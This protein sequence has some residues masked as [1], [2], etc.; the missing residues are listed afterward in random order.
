MRFIAKIALASCVLLAVTGSARADF[1]PEDAQKIRSGLMQAIRLNFKPIGDVA[2]GDAAWSKDIATNADNLAALS[3]ISIQGWVPG[4]DKAKDTHSKP[5]AFTDAEYKIINEGF[6]IE[7][8]KLAAI[9]KSDDKDAIAAQ[10]KKVG[11]TCKN[12]HDKFREE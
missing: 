8:E 10:V 3:R 9:A 2:K 5:E 4:T 11:G 1:K 6:R 7:S 12:C